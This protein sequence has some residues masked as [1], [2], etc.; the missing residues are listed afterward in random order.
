[1]SAPATPVMSSIV[2]VDFG[3]VRTRALIIELVEDS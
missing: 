3:N 2:A 1:M